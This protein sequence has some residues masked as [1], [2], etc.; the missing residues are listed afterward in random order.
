MGKKTDINRKL[1]ILNLF[2]SIFVFG[3]GLIL[4]TQF[5]IGDGA[6]REEWLGLG[7]NFWL[8]IHQASAIGFS[9]GSAAHLQMHWKY[10]KIVAKRWRINLPKK[11][12]SRT[13]EQILLFI[14]TLVVV[15]AGF[16]P[17]IVMPGATLE[18]EEYHKWVDV[19]NRVGI[20]FVIGI[21]VHM[22]R[23]WRRLFGFTKGNHGLILNEFREQADRKQ[24]TNMRTNPM[25][26]KRKSTKYI[27]V[28]TS[29]CEACWDCI[30]ECKQ[31]VLGK[32]DIWFHKHVIIK[33]AEKCCGCKSCISVCPNGVFEPITKTRTAMN[34]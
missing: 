7:K 12:K 13:R 5:H 2:I 27:Y 15:W 14:A 17:W 25:R 26:S 28:D 10:I 32:V 33:N 22:T 20:L 3:T 29:K 6:H 34:Y 11:I 23:R 19:H 21:V 18:V 16:Y 4:F 31:D 24:E 9:V 30:D 8:I 1:N